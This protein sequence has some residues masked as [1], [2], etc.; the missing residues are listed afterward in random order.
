MRARCGTAACATEIP[1]HCARGCEGKGKKGPNEISRR[2]NRV[3]AAVARDCLK[4]KML[5]RAG[6]SYYFMKQPKE[7]Q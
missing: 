1:N 2:E 4:C 3:G 7:F 5:I 6:Y